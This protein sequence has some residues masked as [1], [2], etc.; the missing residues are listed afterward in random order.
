MA[1]VE[2]T[3]HLFSF[4]PQLAGKP[5]CIEATTVAEAVEALDRLAPGIAFYIC[6]EM[7]HLRPHVNVFIGKERVR[8]RRRLSDPVAG[9]DRLFILQALSGG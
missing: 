9:D 4:F 5:I 3:P 1:T 7:G 2:L 6:D 8:D